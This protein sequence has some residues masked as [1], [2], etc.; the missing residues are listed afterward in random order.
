M[1]EAEM[2]L[3]K[4]ALTE[5]LKKLG[6]L[7]DFD[8][9]TEVEASESA[10]VDIVWFDK[11]LPPGE[12]PFK[13]RYIPVLPVVAFEVE[14]G[15]GLNAKHVKGSV[16]NL[17]NLGA[18]LGVIVIAKH[19]LASLQKVPVHKKQKPEELKEILQDRVYRWVYAESQARGRIIVM[20]ESEVV[21]WAAKKGLKPSLAD[22]IPSSE[23]SL[24][25]SP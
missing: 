19:N 1:P 18:Q 7:L 24:A 16:S 11:R 6:E 25:A 21:T 23:V 17:S 20:F 14:W 10:W 12:K 3:T 15:T 4:H 2:G 9:R 22:A 8:V 13:M 5:L